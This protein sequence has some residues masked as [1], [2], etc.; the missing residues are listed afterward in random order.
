MNLHKPDVDEIIT[1]GLG[2]QNCKSFCRAV[3]KSTWLI[4]HVTEI[5]LKSKITHKEKINYLRT[6]RFKRLIHSFYFDSVRDILHGITVDSFV[7]ESSTFWRQQKQCSI[8]H[9]QNSTSNPDRA[10]SY[11]SKIP[12]RFP[13]PTIKIFCHPSRPTELLPPRF[14]VVT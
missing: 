7:L 12:T 6:Q 13:T 5:L 11:C 8:L 2:Q 4:G 14:W 10:V 3:N 1:A 9:R